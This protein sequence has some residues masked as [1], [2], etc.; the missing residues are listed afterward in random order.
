LR[1]VYS[2]LIIIFISSLFFLNCRNTREVTFEE[3]RSPEQLG[4]DTLLELYISKYRKFI[5]SH[6]DSTLFPRSFENNKLN[7]VSSDDWTSGFFPGILWYLYEYSGDLDLLTAAKS[8]TNSLRDQSYNT[9]TH[10]IGFIINS[11]F[12][13][14]YRISKNESYKEVLNTAAKSLASR[15]NDDIGSIKSLDE[16]A[17][18]EFPVLIDNM[19]NLEILYKAWRWNNN[20]EYYKIANKHAL[21]TMEK[22]FRPDFSSFQVVDYD[23]DS[24]QPKY[25]G[26]F[27]GFSDSTAWARGQSWALYGFVLAF[28]ETKDRVYLDQSIRIASYI[29]SHP[30]FPADCIPYWDY[31]SPDIP[32]TV[33]DATAAAILASALID[34]SS[35]SEI[36]HPEQYV[37][38]AEKI[39]YNLVVQ[40][41]IANQNEK[42]NFVL[43]Q[44]VGSFPGNTE[45]GVPIIYGDY[46]L[47][48][49]LIKY[50]NLKINV[51]P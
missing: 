9:S 1:K 38:V 49:A 48:E 37:I 35:Y 12:G 39:I 45:V 28:R 10:D 15:Y 32:N 14:A 19:V 7:M 41:Y 8:W 29:L 16:N 31:L 40:G 46:Y 30:N 43:D 13:Q 6:P 44:G 11:S 50:K 22:H 3:I 24:F 26:S 51:K 2:Y 42:E 33:R 27:Q 18:F 47:L 17:N 20:V 34:L 21:N 36:K 5:D 23:L 25:R 4:I